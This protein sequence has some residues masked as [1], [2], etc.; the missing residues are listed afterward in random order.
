MRL[1][2]SSFATAA[3]ALVASAAPTIVAPEVTTDL[4]AR[5]AMYLVTAEARADGLRI[6]YVDSTFTPLRNAIYLTLVP[7]IGNLNININDSPYW[8]SVDGF[9]KSPR[10]RIPLTGGFTN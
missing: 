2:L 8:P 6:R 10:S 1:L 9:C 5:F 7:N 3:L 4:P